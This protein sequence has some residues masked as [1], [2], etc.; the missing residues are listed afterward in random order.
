MSLVNGVLGFG[1]ALIGMGN[2]YAGSQVYQINVASTPTSNRIENV[3]VVNPHSGFLLA[4][5]AVLLVGGLM[6]VVA[7]IV[8][9]E[10]ISLPTPPALPPS[11]QELP[12]PVAPVVEEE[13]EMGWGDVDNYLESVGG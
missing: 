6:V 12:P 8:P 10:G 1:I 5:G 13:E 3:S 2:I 7:A 11:R 9:K 4:S